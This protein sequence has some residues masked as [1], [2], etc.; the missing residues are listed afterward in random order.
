MPKISIIGAGYVGLT[1][2]VGLASKGYDVI[3]VE[4]SHEKLDTI[5]KG[6]SNVY[7]KN[8]DELL[9]RFVNNK[10]EITSDI[11]HAVRNSDITI[12]CVGTY[13]KTDGSIDLSQIENVSRILGE[14]LKSKNSYHVVVIKSTVVPTTTRRVI[15]PI[16]EES[17]GKRAGMDFGIVV[18]PEFLREGHAIED[19]INP[20]RI[21]IGE[22][23]SKSGIMVEDLY[24]PF[25]SKMIKT[26]LETAEMIKYANNAFLGLL[27]SYSNELANICESI[28]VDVNSVLYGMYYDHR[29]SP[30]IG[31][32]R[33]FP[34]ILSYLAPGPGFGGSCLPKDISAL[35][36]FVENIGYDP[37]IIRSIIEIN[38][39]RPNHIVKLVER[40]LKDLGD[41][42]ITVLGVTF[43][44]DTDDIRES[45]SIDII[46]L[47]LAKGAKVK[48]YDPVAMGNA[49]VV[50]KDGVIYSDSLEDSLKESDACILVTKWSEFKSITPEMLLKLMKIPLLID[51]RRFLDTKEFEGKVRFIGVGL[52]K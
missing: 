38:S 28:G 30:K 42:T 51:C 36:K 20:D 13:S 27:I 18:N 4:K 22:F 9:S 24:K 49:K 6:K 39:N 5:K 10:F 48:L 16:L 14:I 15:L 41:R 2:G 7:E 31:N 50:L 44:P 11:E 12:V 45:P 23:D 21:V 46:R 37:K 34:E 43:K 1:T 35:V 52:G 25:N 3:C 40:E 33:V 8:L 17:S 32:E 26:S 47:L 29:L 19:F